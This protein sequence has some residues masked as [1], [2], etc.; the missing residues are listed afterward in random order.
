MMSSG[1][2]IFSAC[3]NGETLTYICGASQNVRRS[4]WKPNGVSVRL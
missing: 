3:A 1:A 2:S 4:R